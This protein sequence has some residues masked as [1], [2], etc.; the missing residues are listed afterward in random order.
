MCWST[1]CWRRRTRM[2]RRSREVTWT[3]W[4]STRRR[5]RRFP[6][7]RLLNSNLFHRLRAVDCLIVSMDFLWKLENKDNDWW[8]W[9]RWRTIDLMRI[10]LLIDHFSIS[11]FKLRSQVFDE[12][13]T[14]GKQI[15]CS[16]DSFQRTATHIPSTR[17]LLTLVNG[18]FY[19]GDFFVVEIKCS[20]YRNYSLMPLN[21]D[22]ETP[23]QWFT[24]TRTTVFLYSLRFYPPVLLV[25]FIGCRS[26]F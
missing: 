17:I 8:W 2:V 1:W 10:L 16:K 5:W 21:F 24:Q 19:F 20:L 6:K 4:L 3:R 13:C 7:V 23:P 15:G 25:E 9:W 14:N 22:S 12:C 11:K 26:T 18:H